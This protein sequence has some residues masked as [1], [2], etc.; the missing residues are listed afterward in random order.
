MH[1]PPR[2]D[3]ARGFTLIELL[4][5]ISIILVLIALLLPAVESAREAAR[6]A[7]CPNNLRII[8]L[9]LHNYYTVWDVF[10][11]GYASFRSKATGTHERDS[12]WGWGAMILADLEQQAIFNAINFTSPLDSPD[13][14][15]AREARVA[16]FLCPSAAGAYEQVKVHGPLG[17]VLVERLAGSHYVASAGRYDLEASPGENDGIFYLNSRVGISQITDGT[18]N[19]IA[20]GERSR[21]APATWI[22]VVPGGW[23]CPEPRWANQECK[24]SLVMPL[25]RTDLTDDP[26]TVATPNHP[27]AGVDNYHSLHPGG[28]NFSCADGSVKFIINSAAPATFQALAS[29]NGG[30]VISSDSY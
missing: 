16:T 25:G 24:S 27:K 12:G 21:I 4:V 29:R 19:T 1:A 23:V 30:E 26:P 8:G 2:L 6:R 10:P 22:G 13:A 3:V 20:V 15:T 5:V 9:A 28:V 17:D 11:P 7:Q 18:S 14:L